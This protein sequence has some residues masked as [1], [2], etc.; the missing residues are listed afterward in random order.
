MIKGYQELGIEY[1][2]V[3]AVMDERTSEICKMMN[4]RI[5][6]VANA[7]GQRDAMMAAKSPEDVKTISPWLKPAQLKGL[8]TK[9]IMGKGVIMPPY[10]FH[11][12]TTVVAAPG[13]Y[14]TPPTPHPHPRPRI[15]PKPVAPVR[16]RPRRQPRPSAGTIPE[17]TGVT[18][19]HRHD[20][21][22]AQLE[23]RTIAEVTDEVKGTFK[24][25]WTPDSLP[26]RSKP[27]VW[28]KLYPDSAE[29]SEILRRLDSLHSKGDKLAYAAGLA[30]VMKWTHIRGRFVE[31]ERLKLGRMAEKASRRGTVP[32]RIFNEVKREAGAEITSDL[33]QCYQT[34]G[35]VLSDKQLKAEKDFVIG[36]ILGSPKNALSPRS[37]PSIKKCLREFPLRVLGRLHKAGLHFKVGRRKQAFYRDWAHFI[38]LG[39]GYHR[40]PATIRHEI[41]HAIDDLCGAG[42]GHFSMTNR[43]AE[44]VGKS[45]G[46]YSES[47]LE[48]FSGAFT[49]C[50]KARATGTSRV[51]RFN[52]IQQ[53]GRFLDGYDGRI[54]HRGDR[55][56]YGLQY[57]ANNV[58]RFLADAV[59]F[60]DNDYEMWKIYAEIMT[61]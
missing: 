51:T 14:A 46:V 50:Y 61:E 29:R 54:Y 3:L 32:L 52:G 8:D 56:F 16:P 6:P 47:E 43:T 5:I 18:G 15:E 20:K 35:R 23:Q 39:S 37:A 38:Y 53:G 33:R 10:H 59:D 31:L 36:K 49:T 21:R 30:K 22:I 25:D 28:L 40:T 7:A 58:H 42:G 45:V 55:T 1:L 13:E 17:D 11:C 24:T 26:H 9:G 4:G 48:K 27:S 34:V 12:R 57:H 19:R 41:A 2:E 60:H 44:M